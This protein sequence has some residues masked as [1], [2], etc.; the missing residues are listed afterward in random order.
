MTIR[1][2]IVCVITAVEVVIQKIKTPGFNEFIT[3]PDSAI[4]AKSLL[5]YPLIINTIE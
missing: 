2:L 3:K 4:F 1:S 5:A